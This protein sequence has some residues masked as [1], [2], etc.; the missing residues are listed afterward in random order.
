MNTKQKILIFAPTLNEKNNIQIWIERTAMLYPFCDLLIVDDNSSDGTIEIIETIQQKFSNLK[1]HIRLEQMGI[2]S[3]HLWA[4]EYAL[5]NSYDKLVTMDADLSH[6]P[7]EIQKLINESAHS[8]YVVGTRSAKKGGS[9]QSPIVRK[10]LSIW[11]NKVCSTLLFSSLSEYTTS[12]RCY[13]KK[14]LEIV[15]KTPPT[16]NDYSFFIQISFLVI[17]NSLNI[18]EVPIK[19]ESRKFDKSKIP[20]SQIFLSLRTII[21]LAVNKAEK[22]ES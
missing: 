16:V 4:F 19:F 21:N 17:Q 9:N 8:N 5:R 13:D 11:A 15:M 1:L 18:S 22:R 14:S 12:F 7:D 3:A 6:N 2:G 20:R 10:L